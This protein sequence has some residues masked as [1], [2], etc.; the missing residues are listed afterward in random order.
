MHNPLL[1]QISTMP[2]FM[3]NDLNN[4]YDDKLSVDSTLQMG[5]AWAGD[6]IKESCDL[7]FS[8]KRKVRLKRAV[9]AL[10]SPR[11]ELGLRLTKETSLPSL[12]DLV[13][14][15]E[16]WFGATSVQDKTVPIITLP[17][18]MVI[19]FEILRLFEHSFVCQL[20]IYIYS[21]SS[22]ILRDFLEIFQLKKDL[23]PILVRQIDWKSSM[24]IERPWKFDLQ[25][26]F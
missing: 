17:I 1:F 19:Y 25:A 23:S 5:G 9:D 26:P 12:A 16:Y 11:D 8:W 14:G 2:R 15:G 22:Y 6:D 3:E 20:H 4:N 24:V 18:S 13:G 21:V 7:A 10:C